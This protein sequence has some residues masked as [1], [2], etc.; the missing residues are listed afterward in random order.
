MWRL[1]VTGMQLVVL[2]LAAWAAWLGPL[3][4]P[5]FN[6]DARAQAVPDTGDAENWRFGG[7]NDALVTKSYQL[8]AAN[9]WLNLGRQIEA[10]PDQDIVLD[11]AA[12][13]ALGVL[14]ETPTNGFGW[15]TLSWA[16]YARGR[17]AEGAALLALS[18][19]WSPH[20][21]SLAL[22]RVILEMPRWQDMSTEQREAVLDE[23][24]LARWEP[25]R[26]AATQGSK[27]LAAL[28][29]LTRSRLAA[30]RNADRARA[31]Q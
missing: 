18:R 19:T 31:G 15:V 28:W 24:A 7:P 14:A 5:L 10:G 25:S 11:R 17:N 20:S 29:T 30:Q 22:N 9:A 23:M 1:A 12:A 2:A 8:E 6:T 16:A 4:S 27:R 26:V 3:R 21:R 13:H